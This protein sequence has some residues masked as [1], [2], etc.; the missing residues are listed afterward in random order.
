ML[1]FA[2]GL[3]FNWP[4]PRDKGDCMEHVRQLHNAVG[5]L[6]GAYLSVKTKSEPYFFTKGNL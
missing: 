2:F 4:R 6:A 3:G 5:F 1:A